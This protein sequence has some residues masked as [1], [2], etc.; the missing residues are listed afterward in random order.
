M[1][2]V[3]LFCIFFFGRI[4]KIFVKTIAKPRGAVYNK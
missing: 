2:A 1:I 3:K 4:M